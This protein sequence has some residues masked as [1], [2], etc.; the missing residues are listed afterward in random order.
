LHESPALHSLSLHDALPICIEGQLVG[1]AVLRFEQRFIDA[2][3][4]W[5]W[6]NVYVRALDP[7]HPEKGPVMLIE[8]ISEQK[9]NEERIRHLAEDRKST[10]LNSSHVKISYAV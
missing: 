5:F 1:D 2:R 8:D 7:Q 6:A 3:G 4:Q 9:L 10:R